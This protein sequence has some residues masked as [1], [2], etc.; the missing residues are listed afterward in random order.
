MNR[1]LLSLVLAAV[2]TVSLGTN[3]FS[4]YESYVNEFNR[5]YAYSSGSGKTFTYDINEAQDVLGGNIT[6]SF[7]YYG[8]T[9]VSVKGANGSFSLY[10]SYGPRFSASNKGGIWEVTG[11]N[12]RTSDLEEMKKYST[13]EAFFAT[14]GLNIQ[15]ADM[16]DKNANGE[17]KGTRASVSSQWWS[18]VKDALSKGANHSVSISAGSA[19]TGPIATISENGKQMYQIQT[20]NDSST[21]IKITA[22][23][24]YDNKGFMIG[25]AQPTNEL[26][27]SQNGQASG[28]YKMNYTAI[29][30]DKNGVRT[31]TTYKLF[32]WSNNPA[33]TVSG[34]LA[35]GG[36]PSA[37]SKT[38]GTV[39]EIMSITKYSANN[40]TLF[41]K[42]YTTNNTTY[43]AGSQ[44]SFV[45]N[46]VGETIGLYSYTSNG[47][48]TA[49]FNAEGTDSNGNKVGSTTLYDKWGRAAGTVLGGLTDGKNPFK[50][51]TQRR[52][53]LADMN[54][55]ISGTKTA[56]NLAATYTYNS[57]TGRYE[58]NA[59]TGTRIQSVNIY[60]DQILNTN[61]SA[62]MTNGFIDMKKVHTQI[63]RG[64]LSSILNTNGLSGMGY[65]TSDIRKMLTFAQGGSNPLASTTITHSTWDGDN[66]PGRSGVTGSSDYSNVSKTSTSTTKNSSASFG[67]GNYGSTQSTSSET[68]DTYAGVT[69]SNT[70]NF[71]GAQA[72][73]K[74]HHVVTQQYSA[75]TNTVWTESDPAVVGN[76]M[77]NPA[78]IAKALGV[79]EDAFTLDNGVVT[80][81]DGSGTYVL[82]NDAQI[83]MIDGNGFNAAEGE[84]IVV[85]LDDENGLSKEQ[86]QKIQKQVASG[87]TKAMFMGDVRA[88]INGN[89]TMAVNADYGKG[90][91]LNYTYTD[92]KGNV[93]NAID[94][95]MEEITNKSQAVA[96]AR[97]ALEMGEITQA[98]Y[99]S[100]IDASGWIGQNTA[101]NL[102]KFAKGNFSWD[103][104]KTATQNI[105]DA[106]DILLNF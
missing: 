35:S 19:A 37:G 79:S 71:G 91:E 103:E 93:V 106:W 104:N 89:L 51:A 32:D 53:D 63:N 34:G 46:E 48:M 23:Y 99:D 82:V 58:A 59:G 98:E 87:D 1:K 72:Y 66:I 97:D 27:N 6:A 69:F 94:T 43:Y 67:S 73:T 56:A 78:D 64:N 49:A 2:F 102:E 62:I 85:R 83:N 10:D 22:Q 20:D 50:N 52:I 15:M 13:A 24:Y 30:Y 96:Q 9:L 68:K 25:Y 95:A 16:N 28:E 42:D 39:G 74:Q 12:L 76:I 29:T 80:M 5:E 60:P 7:G 36:I 88:D 38:T 54:A 65:T 84:T 11:V 4:A 75:T 100:I 17:A 14:M 105:R 33:A 21:G 81:K 26:T 61:N 77:T 101:D 92:D 45:T 55:V 44:Q 70:I 18:K 3:G 41:S 90:F 31:D 86:I 8:G 47:I 57:S 40:S